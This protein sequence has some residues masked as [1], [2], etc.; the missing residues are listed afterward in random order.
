V[1]F[2]GVQEVVDINGEGLVAQP[3]RAHSI[4]VPPGFTV[5]SGAGGGRGNLGYVLFCR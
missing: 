1:C 2:V 3:D 4:V 5:V